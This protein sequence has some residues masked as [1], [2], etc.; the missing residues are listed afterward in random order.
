VSLHSQVNWRQIDLLDLSEN[1]RYA[2]VPINR[3]Q[4]V[5]AVE[6]A[7]HGFNPSGS[8]KILFEGHRF[9][10]NLQQAGLDPHR[11]V[12]G[13]ESIL[14]KRWTKK[15]YV[16]GSGEHY[17]LQ[18]ARKIDETA[19][20]KS[21]SWGV[22]QI[23]G[24]N[25]AKCGYSSVQ[26]FVAAMQES[27]QKQVEAFFAFLSYGKQPLI[28]HLTD[29]GL[30]LDAFFRGYNGP[31]YKKNG[32]P[33]KY[34]RALNALE[35]QPQADFKP[36]PASA[37]LQAGALIGVPVVGQMLESSGI[38][39]ASG[40]VS[41]QSTE[42]QLIFAGLFLLGLARLGWSWWRDRRAGRT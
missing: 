20:L 18:Q 31:A 34:Q 1:Q 15:H 2:G 35:L 24:E 40:T 30:D 13:N 9:W 16:G 7:G 41:L 22:A 26:D 19:A 14:Y 8:P 3:L 38:V 32:Y 33:Q 36:A 12:R 42:G 17:R 5:L 27:T 23:L 11:F 21:A 37:R 25:Y 4:A 6:S 29:D 39:D 10:R 28:R